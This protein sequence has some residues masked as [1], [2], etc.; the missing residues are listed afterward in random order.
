ME[1]IDCSIPL[2]A[3]TPVFPGDESF[4]LNRVA[5]FSARDDV[6]LSH[7]SASTHSGTHIDAPAHFI[8]GGKKLNE[9]PIERLVGKVRVVEIFDSECITL[10]SLQKYDL[11]NSR[12]IFFKTR[13]SQ[14][15]HTHP[16]EFI[17]DFVYLGEDAARYLA[18]LELFMVGIDYLSIDSAES[19]NYP[20][21]ILLLEKEILIV[22]GLNLSEVSTGTYDLVCAPL[23]I[24]NA[25]AAPARV[26]LLKN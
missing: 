2:S 21:H 18:G 6:E 24:E 26:L 14:L 9:I 20:A 25:E 10:D 11:Q 3:K 1:I 13:N 19:E 4:S 22:E 17:Q 5:E 15:W 23:K 7:F 8:P 16:H 12:R